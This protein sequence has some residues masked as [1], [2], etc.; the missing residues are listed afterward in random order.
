MVPSIAGRGWR[1]VV[2]GALALTSIALPTTVA[3][4]APAECATIMS[5]NNIHAGQTGIG[6]TV[7]QGTVPQQFNVEVL[8]VLDNG[9]APGRDMVVIEISD[10]GGNTFIDEAGGIWSGMSGSPVYINGKLAGA[11]AYGFSSVASPVGGMTPA[12][13][14]SSILDYAAA[15]RMPSRPP[16]ASASLR[17]CV[18]ISPDGRCD[19]GSG[20]D[21]SH[22]CHVPGRRFG[23]PGPRPRS[24]PAEP[25]AA[26]QL[27]VILTSGGRAERVRAARWSRAGPGR[28]L[29][30]GP[31]LW[32][33]HRR[34][35]SAPRPTSAA[36]RRLPLVTRCSS[37]VPL[38]TAPTTPTRSP[39]LHDAVFGSF[40]LANITDPF[41]TV[42][43]DRLIGIRAALG[44]APT[45]IPVQARVSVERHGQRS[46]R[47]QPGDDG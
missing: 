40:K 28:Q 5:V 29:R 23:R 1:L 31:V 18:K 45:L 7:A 30:S 44:E 38:R 17:Q 47:S 39:S 13:T 46:H 33:R 20:F 22:G 11:V 24:T 26:G 4:A 25:R 3:A 27:D 32:R 6:W 41:G 14:W 37:A 12:R 2:A 16:T 21:R 34:Q 8:G 43:Q 19:R 36:I 42:D 9:I 15:G 10:V 35:A